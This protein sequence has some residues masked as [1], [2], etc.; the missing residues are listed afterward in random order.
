MRNIMI[1]VI[2]ELIVL[3]CWCLYEWFVLGGIWEIL[4]LIKSVIEVIILVVLFKLF[5][6]KVLEFFNCLV[7]I[8]KIVRNK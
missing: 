5:V 8:F 4:R 2:K 7:I 3:V 6:S 1:D